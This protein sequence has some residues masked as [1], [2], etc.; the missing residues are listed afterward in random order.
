MDASSML[1]AFILSFHSKEL[2][3]DVARIWKG[4]GFV[5]LI[6]L[7]ALCWAAQMIR[8]QFQVTHFA[9]Q[10]GAAIVKQIPDI[11]IS[12]G[13]VSTN[14]QTPYFIRDA[15]GDAIAIIDLTGQY[16]SLEDTT[17]KM[18]LTQDRLSFGDNGRIRTMDLKKVNSFHIDQARVQ[19]WLNFAQGWFA[20]MLY[21]LALVFSFIYRVLQALIYALFGMLFAKMMKVALDYL[22]LLRLAIVAVTP[23]IILD[24]L[25]SLLGLHTPLWGPICFLIAM[26]YLVFAIKANAGQEIETLEQ[27][28]PLPPQQ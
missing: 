9:K 20:V 3:R 23:A 22:T 10:E 2:Y 26:G 1:R 14:V 13:R 28:A 17:A 5:Y 11:T 19:G 15:K 21:V 25:H 12:Q 7:L 4:T 27:P 24:T 16:T 18:L 8:V 6:L